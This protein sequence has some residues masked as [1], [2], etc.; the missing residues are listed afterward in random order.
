MPECLINFWMLGQC[1]FDRG[2]KSFPCSE[3]L[4]SL[5]LLV[6]IKKETRKISHN[7]EILGKAPF[8]FFK[9]NCPKAIE[10]DVNVSL[11]EILQA[12]RSAQFGSKS[13]QNYWAVI[14]ICCNILLCLITV[15]AFGCHALLPLVLHSSRR[16][17]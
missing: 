5:E 13:Y 15:S 17:L 12:E 14:S 7:W 8:F 11:N 2:P 16:W 6:Q 3:T 1:T 9:L 10:V 4:A